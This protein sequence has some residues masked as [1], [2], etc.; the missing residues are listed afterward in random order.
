MAMFNVVRW[1][2]C[3]WDLNCQMVHWFKRRS[4]WPWSGTNCQ[5]CKVTE[6]YFT[7]FILWMNSIYL[8]QPRVKP[9][10]CKDSII[11]AETMNELLVFY[12]IFCS[13]LEVHIFNSSWSISPLFSVSEQP[14]KSWLAQ[15][16]SFFFLPSILV[17][18]IWKWMQKV[19]L[20]TLDTAWCLINWDGL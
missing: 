20:E 13:C 7:E 16:H 14:A 15:S 19:P 3:Y 17:R 11:C 4:M 8:M 1:C 9:K 5:P 12:T 10:Q 6:E 2:D 18:L